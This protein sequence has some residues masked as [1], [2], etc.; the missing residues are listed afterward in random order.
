MKNN[1]DALSMEERREIG[2]ALAT[3]AGSIVSLVAFALVLG[4]VTPAPAFATS[5]S[6]PA[7]N[8]VSAVS[9]GPQ[10]SEAD[11]GCGCAEACLVVSR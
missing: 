3:A 1:L 7:T 11:P 4:L 8:V 6:T 10:L 5:K 9:A 2:H